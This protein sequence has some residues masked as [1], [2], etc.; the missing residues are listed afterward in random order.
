M[1][2]CWSELSASICLEVFL[3]SFSHHSSLCPF[4]IFRAVS[5]SP[6]DVTL[7]NNMNLFVDGLVV[8]TLTKL[9][10]KQLSSILAFLSPVLIQFGA[11]NDTKRHKEN[12]H[13]NMMNV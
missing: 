5:Y 10:L 2:V 12:L 8:F 9:G 6:M 3:D 4:S 1:V 13:F 11:Q 7:L